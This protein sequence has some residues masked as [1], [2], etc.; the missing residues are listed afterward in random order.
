MITGES[1]ILYNDQAITASG[2]GTALSDVFTFENTYQ[3]TALSATPMLRCV[4]RCVEV[5][6][7]IT[8]LS[9]NMQHLD[10]GG[11]WANINLLRGEIVLADLNTLVTSGDP[12]FDGAI[13]TPIG[14]TKAHN[15]T[16]SVRLI[17]TYVTSSG[18]PT[19]GKLWANFAVAGGM[20][21][22]IDRS[23][24]HGDAHVSSVQIPTGSG[25]QR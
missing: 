13:D 15:V 12:V 25:I 18:A 7:N 23:D 2:S 4:V 3:S 11:S 8:N 1:E 14:D 10:A 22:Q 16:I 24:A 21:T 17:T 19:T 20:G 5:F 9:V 6:N